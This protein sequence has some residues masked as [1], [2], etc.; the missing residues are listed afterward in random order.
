MTHEP[1]ASSDAYHEA[2]QTWKK[3]LKKYID[4]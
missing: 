1:V 3:E 4:N 2:Y